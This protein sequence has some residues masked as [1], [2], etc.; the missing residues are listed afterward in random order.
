MK[1]PLVIRNNESHETSCIDNEP[2]ARQMLAQLQK[3]CP[4]SLA[5]IR[6]VEI[7][8]QAI[9]LHWAKVPEPWHF[10]SLSDWWSASASES[11]VQMHW[12]SESVDPTYNRKEIPTLRR[13]Y[14]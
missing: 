9:V 8:S 11:K 2:L 1:I 6:L 14:S 13:V 12:Y 4:E 3:I 7:T 5:G 10:E